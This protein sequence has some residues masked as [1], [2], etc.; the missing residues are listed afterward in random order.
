M[1]GID[2]PF[3]DPHNDAE[4][5]AARIPDLIVDGIRTRP[6]ARA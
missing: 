5:A 3:R 2:Y 4:R 1:P 6:A